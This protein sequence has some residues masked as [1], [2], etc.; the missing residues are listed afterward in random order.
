MKNLIIIDRGWNRIKTE[1]QKAGDSYTKVGLPDDGEVNAG[2][3]IGSGHEEATD[4]SELIIVGAVHEFGAPNRNIPAR[5]FMRTTYDE[6]K[7][8]LQAMLEKQYDKFIRG[9][10][11]IEKAL[12][13]IGEW[14]TGKTIAK[15]NKIKSPPLAQ[16]TI[17]RKGSKNPLVDT[18]QMKQS[19]Q[20]IEVIKG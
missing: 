18:G 19:I 9:S 11:T 17:D 2:D 12:G 5:P 13:V 6:T 3:K 16:S 14:L 10:T 7:S 4:M 20:H 1:L 8:Q 15:I